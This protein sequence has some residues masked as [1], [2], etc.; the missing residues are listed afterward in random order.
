MGTAAK[1]QDLY[2]SHPRFESIARKILEHSFAQMQ[3]DMRKHYTETPEMRYK[4]LITER[5]SLIQRVP[6]YQIASY[7]GVQPETL[8]RMRGR[9]A[10]NRTL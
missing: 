2:D 7:I 6:Q 5:P 1:E 8:S 4:K 9:M 10:R 3:T